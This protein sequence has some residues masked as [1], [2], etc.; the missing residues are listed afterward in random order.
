MKNYPPLSSLFIF[1]A[2][3]TLTACG[4]GGGGGNGGGG[5]APDNIAPS[6]T[7]SSTAT[8]DENTSGVVYSASA[9]DADGDPLTF[10]LS[11][12]ADQNRFNIDGASGELTLTTPADFEAP[13]D[14]NTDNVYEVTLRVEDGNGGSDQLALALTV[15]D[16]TQL[17]L[18]VS[19]P[20]PNANLGGD[21]EFTSV[22][23]FVEDLEDGEVLDSDIDFVR[24]G[25]RHS[26]AHGNGSCRTLAHPATPDFNS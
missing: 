11:G 22:T 19:Y 6:I 21:V 10:S 13:S 23:G 24:P 15:E 12:G 25:G 9:I 5:N 1:L 8:M 2:V 3:L 4:G 16:V 18:N 7:S 14:A 26:T 17:A 20:T